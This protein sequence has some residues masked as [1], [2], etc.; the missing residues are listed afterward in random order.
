MTHYSYSYT[1]SDT[2]KKLDRHPELWFPDGTVVIMADNTGFCVYAGILARYSIVL[3]SM[4]SA[5]DEGLDESEMYEG[6]PKLRLYD[7][8]EDLALFLKVMHDP[9]TF[10]GLF[11]DPDISHNNYF[12]KIVT[13]IRLSTH[14]PIGIQNNPDSSTYHLSHTTIL[15]LLFIHSP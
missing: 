4:V 8:P 3:Q 10:A 14:S 15:I 1:S 11:R 5:F 13:L 2:Q 7:T 12:K 6:R 9:S